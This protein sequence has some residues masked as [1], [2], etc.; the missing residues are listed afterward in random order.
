MRCLLGLGVVALVFGAAS[1]A[2]AQVP[3]KAV[4]LK[5]Y[6]AARDA[7]RTSGKPIFLVF[8]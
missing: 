5:D 7:A 8:R 2:A 4:W 6:A 1:D 3:N